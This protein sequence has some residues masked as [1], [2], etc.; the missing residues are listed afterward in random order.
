MLDFYNFTDSISRQRTNYDFARPRHFWLFLPALFGALSK[1]R[2]KGFTELGGG[3]QFTLPLDFRMETYLRKYFNQIFSDPQHLLNLTIQVLAIVIAASI[4]WWV[5]NLITKKIRNKYQDRPFFKNNDQLFFLVNRAG[6][7]A[8]LALTGIWLVKWRTVMIPPLK[9]TRL[10]I[11]LSTPSSSFGARFG[12]RLALLTLVVIAVAG[13]AAAPLRE[14]PLPADLGLKAQLP[15]MPVVRKWGDEPP[16]N[17]EAWLELPERVLRER[18]GGIMNCRH[19]Y[20]V[21]SGGGSNGAFGAGLL[22]GWSEHGFRPDFQIVTGIS[23]GALIAPFA[24]LG[25]EYNDE[26][27]EMYTRYSTRD[28]VQKRGLLALIR[29]DAATDFTPLRNLLARYLNDDVINRIAAEGRK[30]RS[31]FI[32]TTNL[33]AGRP[34][35]W[36]ITR[37]AATQSEGAAELIHKVVLASAA[38]PGMFPP[39]LI[40]VEAEGKRYDEMHVDGGVTGQLFLER[41]GI[42]W[43]KVQERLQVDG[44]PK[45]YVIRNSKL[46]NRWETVRRR[47]LPILSRS[48]STLIA[49]QGK[50]DLAR[51]YIAAEEYGFDYYLAYIPNSFGVES[52]EPFDPVYMGA[53]FELGYDLAR[54]GYPWVELN[55]Q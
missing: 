24:F 49:S 47:L 30:G 55:R 13:C 39:V 22:V 2:P 9:S 17:F 45:V 31:L 12:M 26:L 14:N 34:V 40:D 32:G 8:I 33:D 6:H 27:K 20:L 28:L 1:K 42:D 51:I 5:F 50:G 37:I 15:G 41:Y 29:G 48:L 35:I 21:I 43:K 16:A 19:D 46:R 4:A 36:D 3:R 44:R 52:K 25:H 54:K 10:S 53:L 23:T 7:Y 11:D 38:I 18:Y